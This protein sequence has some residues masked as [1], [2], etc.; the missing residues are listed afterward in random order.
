MT[1]RGKVPKNKTI[2][3]LPIVLMSWPRSLLFG[4]NL[5]LHKIA[6]KVA[7]FAVTGNH[8]EPWLPVSAL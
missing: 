7:D 3:N 4:E 6:S 1:L 8:M 2:D 5:N